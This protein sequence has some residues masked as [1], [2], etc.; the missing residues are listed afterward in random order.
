MTLS[1]KSNK[2]VHSQYSKTCTLRNLI[3]GKICFLQVRDLSTKNAS[4]TVKWT[5]LKAFMTFL[6]IKTHNNYS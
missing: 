2:N 4:C 1:A 5:T 6:H 3:R